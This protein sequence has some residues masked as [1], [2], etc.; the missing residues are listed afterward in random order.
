MPCWFPQRRM[1]ELFQNFNIHTSRQQILP[2]L[3]K[4]HSYKN[5]QT[6]KKKTVEKRAAKLNAS[7]AAKEKSHF[8]ILKNINIFVSHLYSFGN[9]EEEPTRLCWYRYGMIL[10]TDLINLLMKFWWIAPQWGLDRAS[11]Q[12]I[13]YDYSIA[14]SFQSSFESYLT[15]LW[16]IMSYR[17]HQSTSTMNH[18]NTVGHAVI[19]C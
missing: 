2:K 1:L 8:K 7:T 14:I 6:N 13:L 10:M 11:K 4:V 3:G 12:N 9:T 19:S 18:L 17:S 16:L 5:K 15:Y